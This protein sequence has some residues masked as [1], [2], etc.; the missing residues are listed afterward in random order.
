MYVA[1]LNIIVFGKENRPV[2]QQCVT[3]HMFINRNTTLKDFYE[4]TASLPYLMQGQSLDSD[5][6]TAIFAIRDNRLQKLV[7]FYIYYYKNKK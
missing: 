1:K 5:Y 7:M 6:S 4:E 3:K 2:E